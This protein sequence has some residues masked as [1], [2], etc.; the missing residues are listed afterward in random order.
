MVEKKVY[1][2][3]RSITKKRYFSPIII[4]IFQ[5]I[6]KHIGILFAN[7]KRFLM[8]NG[9]L[10]NIIPKNMATDGK[11]ERIPTTF[12]AFEQVGSGKTFQ[13]RTRPPQIWLNDKFFGRW[14]NDGLLFFIYLCSQPV[15][16]EI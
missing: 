9:I 6:I 7:W 16:R 1:F 3:I 10:K 2:F 8:F 12:K 4:R 11:Q 15:S 13:P 5:I 14:L